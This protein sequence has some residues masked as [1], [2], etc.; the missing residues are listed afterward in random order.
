MIK[1]IINFIKPKIKYDT[2][3]INW[4]DRGGKSYIGS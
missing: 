4:L 3:K 1:R 2:S